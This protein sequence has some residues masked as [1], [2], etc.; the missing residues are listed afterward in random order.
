V[1]VMK[2]Q[3]VREDESAAAAAAAQEVGTR[4]AKREPHHPPVACL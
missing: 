1:A 2:A 3:M 4:E